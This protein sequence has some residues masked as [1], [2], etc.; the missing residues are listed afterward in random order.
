MNLITYTFT[1]L[2]KAMCVALSK[3]NL[4]TAIQASAERSEVPSETRTSISQTSPGRVATAGSVVVFSSVDTNSDGVLDA[5]ELCGAL[6]DSGATD[7]EI[8]QLFFALDTNHDN[9]ISMDEF[10]AGFQKYRRQARLSQMRAVL[11]SE[12][13]AFR[14][15]HRDWI[16]TASFNERCRSG[17]R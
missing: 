13:L 8:E 10:V 17:C 1:I 9:L 5:S 2:T 14:D 11:L 12:L 6:S 4:P 15:K 7:Y 3:H 16:E